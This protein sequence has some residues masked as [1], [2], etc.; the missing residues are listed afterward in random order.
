V[1][2]VENEQKFILSIDA[3]EDIKNICSM[4]SEI[5]QGYLSTN[6]IIKVTTL[7]EQT[8][9][10]LIFEYNTKKNIIFT[11]S[12]SIT[13]DD[14]EVLRDEVEIVVLKTRYSLFTKEGTWKIDLF[15]NEYGEAYFILAEYE[16]PSWQEKLNNIPNI[17]QKHLLK[18]IDKDD[19]YITDKSLSDESYAINQL[20][21][22]L[23]EQAD[24][25]KKPKEIRKIKESVVGPE[26]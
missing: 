21:V 4:P 26:L 17:I 14:F 10:E 16:R 7:N 24:V 13:E 3:E 8:S 22:I 2:T 19:I 18:T 11:T 5:Q 15:K 23:Q 1:K 20:E 25:A 6:I 9:Y 12:V